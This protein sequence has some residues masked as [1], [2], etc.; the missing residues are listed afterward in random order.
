MKP[1]HNIT[2]PELKVSIIIGT[3]KLIANI[4]NMKVKNIAYLGKLWMILGNFKFSFWPIFWE[5]ER[6]RERENM[7]E[8]IWKKKFRQKSGEISPQKW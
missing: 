6:E 4:P 8:L 3:I 5:R 1:P 2:D 7:W